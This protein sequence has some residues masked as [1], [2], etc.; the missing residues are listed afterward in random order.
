MNAPQG[1]YLKGIFPCILIFKCIRHLARKV[2]NKVYVTLIHLTISETYF[3]F[4]KDRITES[5]RQSKGCMWAIVQY[6]WVVGFLMVLPIF[7]LGTVD[8]G[9]NTS[10]LV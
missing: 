3:K 2:N 1:I 10:N 5:D 9:R 4:S 7:L 8:G 6:E